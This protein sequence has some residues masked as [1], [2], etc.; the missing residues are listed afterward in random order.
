MQDG[1]F[2]TTNTY[3]GAKEMQRKAPRR[4]LFIDS[5]SKSDYAFFFVIALITK[6]VPTIRTAPMGSAMYH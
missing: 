2:F 3:T 6:S 4:E 1:S 5:L